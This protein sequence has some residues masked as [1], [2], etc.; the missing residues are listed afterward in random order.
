MLYLY[1]F[2]S[3]LDFLKRKFEIFV[4]YK[5]LLLTGSLALAIA[6]ALNLSKN[7]EASASLNSLVDETLEDL[8]VKY[9]E[10]DEKEA[11]QLLRTASQLKRDSDGYV[12]RRRGEGADGFP[13]EELV[14][15]KNQENGKSLRRIQKTKYDPSGAK[16]RTSLLDEE[17]L[18]F[19]M[20]SKIALKMTNAKNLRN[21]TFLEMANVSSGVDS[22]KY[23]YEIDKGLEDKVVITKR[24]AIE[25]EMINALLSERF[26]VAQK[27]LD[28]SL[29]DAILRKIIERSIIYVTE[30]VIDKRS[31]LLLGR[32]EYFHDGSVIK[33]DMVD[34]IELR[35]GLSEAFFEIPPE[36]EVIN[37]NSY[38][39]IKDYSFFNAFGDAVEH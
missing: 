7:D 11:F 15:V 10:S 39:D 12:T 36:Y 26:L 13:F 17:G 24:M 1:S 38:E 30:Y 21:R 22:F 35:T 14:F 19:L 18:V 34:E 29:E 8:S 2:A 9:G 31:G 5:I 23:H 28:D 3:I 33:N 32:V 20:S 4:K 37:I 6:F 25:V 16:M 27:I